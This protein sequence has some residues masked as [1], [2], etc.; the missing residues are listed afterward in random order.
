MSLL[1]MSLSGAVMILVIVV[2]RALEHDPPVFIF[3]WI[4]RMSYDIM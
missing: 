4:L 2:I 3:N 1:E